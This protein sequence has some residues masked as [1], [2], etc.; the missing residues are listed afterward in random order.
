MTGS[1][2]LALEEVQQL[3]RERRITASEVALAYADAF[4]R[5]EG[6]V[7]AFTMF[8]V[9][10][11]LAEALHAD[12]LI[13]RASGRPLGGIGVSVKDNIDV[14]GQV[15][16]AGSARPGSPAGTD[17]PS[18]ALLRAGG[19][20]QCGRSNMHEFAYGA[21]NVNTKAHTTHNPWDLSRASGGSSGGAAV[22]VAVGAAHA[23]LGTD[24]GG[25]VRIPAALSGVTGF[26]PT[27]RMVPIAGVFPLSTSLD[28]VGVLSRSAV[29]CSRVLDVLA[30]PDARHHP[31]ALSN[32]PGT[33]A[34]S[35]AGLRF[36]LLE[37]S[38]AASSP[39]VRESCR[40]ALDLVDELG[41]RIEPIELPDEAEARAVTS[42]IV[43]YEA[44]RVHAEGLRTRREDYGRDVLARLDAGLGVS[45]AAY[46]QY[47]DRRA[48]LAER[49]LASQRNVD[50]V[51][52]PTV[53]VVAPLVADCVGPG[54]A[55][56]QACLV[57]LTYTFNVT[58]QPAISLPG[59]LSESSLP[60]GLQIVGPLGED[61]AVLAVAAVLQTVSDW[62]TRRPDREITS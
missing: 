55:D 3:L 2:D 35:L 39:E 18:W 37:S 27:A 7:S 34:Q 8:D 47:L 50:F 43:S 25:S 49:L 24:T 29:G 6:R 19:A 40:A 16:A 28:T 59:P 53:P 51:L 52:G 9:D 58:G 45:D 38:F 26:K 10:S 56:I 44:A 20:M 46:R 13:S 15:T 32:N 48:A 60:V 42:V 61:R 5:W 23:A 17:A 33:M 11:L 62:H 36:G 31:G 57:S 30:P 14:R 41:G 4:D 1:A 54:A 22:S 21:S 12:A